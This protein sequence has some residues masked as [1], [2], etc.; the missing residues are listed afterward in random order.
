MVQYI[1][2]LGKIANLLKN[3]DVIN[4]GFIIVSKCVH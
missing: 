1:V 4:N 2:N 3:A